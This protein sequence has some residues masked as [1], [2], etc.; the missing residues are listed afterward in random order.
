M[1]LGVDKLLM[2]EAWEMILV[3]VDDR[4]VDGA[5]GWVAEQ[6]PPGHPDII[7]TGWEERVRAL[8]ARGIELVDVAFTLMR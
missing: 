3:A 4:P 1:L 6:L 2:Q 8:N 5:S 7:M